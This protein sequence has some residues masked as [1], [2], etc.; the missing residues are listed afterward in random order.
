M[1]VVESATRTVIVCL[2]KSPMEFQEHLPDL[3]EEMKQAWSTA[4]PEA[5]TNEMNERLTTTNETTPMTT[6]EPISGK[7]EN[8]VVEWKGRGEEGKGR[9]RTHMHTQREASN[10]TGRQQQQHPRKKSFYGLAEREFK[11]DEEKKRKQNY[12][13]IFIGFAGNVCIEINK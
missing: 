11:R 2:A 10:L 3:C 9:E 1:F 4:Y 13:Y 7:M 6:A 8:R 5:W 12:I